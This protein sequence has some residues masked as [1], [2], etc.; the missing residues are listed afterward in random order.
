[1][2]SQ[3]YGYPFYLKTLIVLYKI[4]EKLIFAFFTSV[5]IMGFFSQRLLKILTLYLQYSYPKNVP[6]S[7][8]FLIGRPNRA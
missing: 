8:A 4:C 1:M 2:I 6:D 3:N 7:H 5:D